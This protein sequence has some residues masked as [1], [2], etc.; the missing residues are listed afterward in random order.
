MNASW[1]HV[2]ENKT[3]IGKNLLNFAIKDGVAYVIYYHTPTEEYFQ[4]FLP[5]VKSIITSL[6]LS[7]NLSKII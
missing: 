5:Q 1:N 6:E 2:D 7:G 4:N 3:I